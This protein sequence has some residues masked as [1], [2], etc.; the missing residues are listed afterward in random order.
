MYAHV[1]RPASIHMHVSAHTRRTCK[2]CA[3]HLRR[4]SHDRLRRRVGV[5]FPIL[6]DHLDHSLKKKSLR[7]GLRAAFMLVLI[8]DA[9]SY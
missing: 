2:S 7:F 3:L 9:I 5:C 8:S 4:K 1:H 6:E